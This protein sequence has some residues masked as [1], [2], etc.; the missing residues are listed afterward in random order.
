MNRFL[1]DL[2]IKGEAKVGI[3]KEIKE[4]KEITD[5]KNF[6][7]FT[8]KI[9]TIGR[10]RPKT[11]AIICD[12]NENMKFIRLDGE[13]EIVRGKISLLKE[14]KDLHDTDAITLAQFEELRHN[15]VNDINKHL[16]KQ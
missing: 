11:Y 2:P 4:Q 7:R 10:W 13:N 6:A 14:L 1:I 15:I 3:T 16:E 12:G 5:H 8:N 9:E